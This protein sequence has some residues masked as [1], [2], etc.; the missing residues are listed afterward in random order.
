ML[1][2]KL[3][4]LIAI[5]CSVAYWLAGVGCALVFFG[6]SRRRAHPSS[7]F[8]PPV[9][10][11]RPMRGLDADMEANLQSLAI[12]DW[13]CCQLI[14]GVEDENDPCVPVIRQFLAG[15]PD[16]DAKLVIGASGGGAN[17]KVNN[18]KTMLP[19]ARHDLIILCD[20]DASLA[21]DSIRRIVQPLADEKTGLTCCPYLWKNPR[22]L[23]A[24]IEAL[25]FCSE[26]VPSV[27]LVE[28][29]T[30][31]GFALG[32]T[33]AVRRRCLE[34]IGGFEA[35]QDYLA[36]DYW[37]GKLIRDR[38]HK[39]ALS[40]YVVNLIHPETTWPQMWLHQLR[41]VRTY[42]VCQPLGFF[43]SVLTHGT[44]WATVFLILTLG[45]PLGWTVWIA[46]LGLRLASAMI[47]QTIHLPDRMTTRYFWLLPLRDWCATAWW[48]LAY[49]GNRVT[50]RGSSFTL[51]PD[52]KL[53]SARK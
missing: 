4:C 45:A 38:G 10:I 43:F 11:L 36:D 42:R 44:T 19:H 22:T 9:S 23:P 32:A 21:P 52:G 34:E 7:D 39:L 50:W 3:F 24:A 31:L 27:L 28:Q 25:T 26:F 51:T 20:S 13:P 41:L 2:L 15:H 1:G 46:T 17:R 16:L 47:L 53:H 5:A 33:V 30:G 8:T 35:I 49:T 18:L 6:R 14:F 29:T 37:L 48:L 12:L 40:D